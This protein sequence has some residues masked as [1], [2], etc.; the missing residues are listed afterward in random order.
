MDAPTLAIT[1]TAFRRH[2]YTKQVLDALSACRGIEGC[3]F[4]PTLDPGPPHVREVFKSWDSCPMKL[5][6]NEFKLGCNVNTYYALERGFAESRWVFHLEDDTVPATDAIEFI[7]WGLEQYEHDTSVFAI[8]LWP[9]NRLRASADE[10][11]FVSRKNCFRP[12][13]WAT[14]RDRW[15]TLKDEWNFADPAVAWD[16][17]IDL[18]LRRGRE[19]ILPW[20]SRVKNIGAENGTYVPSPKWHRE[21]QHLEYWSNDYPGPFHYR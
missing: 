8:G 10:A 2:R 14:W 18:N 15:D 5:Q 16:T 3:I 13:G 4:L 17:H 12:W 21:N 6:Y 7:L 9:V 20:V 19:Q 1:M 11:G